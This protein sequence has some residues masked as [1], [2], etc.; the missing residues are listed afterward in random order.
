[1]T[2]NELRYIVALADERNFRRAAER[3][4]VSQPALSLAVAKLEDELGVS[5]FERGRNDVTPTPI[6][7]RVVDQARRVLLEAGRVKDIAVDG[8]DDLKGAVRLG[9]I[10]TI[11]PWLIPALV[12]ELQKVAP[13]MPLALEEN[14]TSELTER[15]KD[16]RI[17]VAILAAPFDVPGL[18]TLPL[19][20]EDFVVV[21]PKGHPF[22]RRK[23]I[24][25]DML[26]GEPLLRLGEG[27]CFA[28]QVAAACPGSDESARTLEGNSLETIRNMVASGLGITVLPRSAA[29]GAYPQGLLGVVPFSTPVPSRRVLMAW[30]ES[31]PR[32]GARAAL[33]QAVRDCGLAGVSRLQ[34]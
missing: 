1:M 22:L 7:A 25:P 17:D 15:L 27:H 31:W 16:G 9:V 30:R 26:K 8:R 21:V 24:D 34:V 23:T 13:G 2:L 29:M 18:S 11:G 32:E 14:L 4:F 3:V 6:G 33:A 5:L 12:P 20:E 28:D 19:Y 10:Y